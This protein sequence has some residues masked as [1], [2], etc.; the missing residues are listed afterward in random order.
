MNFTKLCPYRASP[1]PLVLKSDCGPIPA[2]DDDLLPLKRS[3]LPQRQEGV[4]DLYSLIR[5][6]ERQRSTSPCSKAVE[7]FIFFKQTVNGADLCVSFRPWGV[8]T[9][10]LF[11][12]RI[13]KGGLTLWRKSR[14]PSPVT[15]SAFKAAAQSLAAAAAAPCVRTTSL[16]GNHAS[17]THHRC[18]SS[19]QESGGGKIRGN[20]RVRNRVK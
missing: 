16:P 12:R 13:R 11:G 1:D 17:C 6:P 3:F 2:K 4:L 20:G 5:S 10:N 8:R 18:T 19:H 9:R 14:V 7:T 15:A